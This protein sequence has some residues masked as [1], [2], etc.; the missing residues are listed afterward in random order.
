M[1]TPRKSHL[2]P[3]GNVRGVFSAFQPSGFFS[4]PRHPWSSPLSYSSDLGVVDLEGIAV[5][6]MKG[7]SL[8]HGVCLHLPKARREG[9]QGE[10]LW[11]IGHL[12][13]RR[14]DIA[15]SSWTSVK[16]ETSSHNSRSPWDVQ[17][18]RRAASCFSRSWTGCCRGWPGVSRLAVTICR[19]LSLGEETTASRTV[20]GPCMAGSAKSEGCGEASGLLAQGAAHG[21][22]QKSLH[23]CCLQLP[24]RTDKGGTKRALIPPSLLRAL[25]PEPE[26]VRRTRACQ[27]Q[28]I[29][30]RGRKSFDQRCNGSFKLAWTKL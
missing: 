14:G 2:C 15:F 24:A 27:E 12:P 19:A 10:P 9:F 20:G 17:W 8:L 23:V 25:V 16:V 3:T 5:F 11:S 30:C 4:K 18:G 26:T 28:S 13:K 7:N 1:F 22:S 29:L 21:V 6:L